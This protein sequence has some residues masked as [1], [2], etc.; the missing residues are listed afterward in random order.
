[1]KFRSWKMWTQ[2]KRHNC[3]C[4]IK[5]GK[6]A[7]KHSNNYCAV[8]QLWL[9]IFSHLFEILAKKSN[10]G[11]QSL[12]RIHLLSLE[13]SIHIFS[14][15][16]YFMCHTRLVY[17]IIIRMAEI[18]YCETFK[19]WMLLY[20]CCCLCEFILRWF[21]FLRVHCLIRNEIDAI[22]L[23]IHLHSSNKWESLNEMWCHSSWNCGRFS[24]V[25]LVPFELVLLAFKTQIFLIVCSEI[26]HVSANSC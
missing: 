7:R 21:F 1:M 9:C 23:L 11:H 3:C 26:V 15:V 24:C 8:C 5:L 16:S 18:C 19:C 22:F 2:R 10:H 25:P 4:C 12:T 20:A 13:K 14:Y 6:I 17:Y